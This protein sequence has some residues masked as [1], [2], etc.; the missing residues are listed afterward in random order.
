MLT[1]FVL[2][3]LRVD[4]RTRPCRRVTAAVAADTTADGNSLQLDLVVP[5]FDR[6]ASKLQGRTLSRNPVEWIW[7][8]TVDTALRSELLLSA[9]VDRLASPYIMSALAGS[10]V[11][12][13]SDRVQ[14]EIYSR[15]LLLHTLQF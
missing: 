2:Q 11:A 12:M 7:Q 9:V 14:D 1:V 5:H 4:R 3:A 8:A 13:V 15:S 6:R 10:A